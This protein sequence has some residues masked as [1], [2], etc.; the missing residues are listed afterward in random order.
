MFLTPDQAPR[1]PQTRTTLLQTRSALALLLSAAF[2]AG[3]IR[4]TTPDAVAPATEESPEE[5]QLPI[6][7]NGPWTD[8]SLSP[9]KR[10]ELL[11]AEMSQAEKLRLV[12][13]YFGS[14]AEW[15]AYKAPAEARP[16]SAGYVPGNPRLGIPPQWQTDAGIGVAT[17]GSAPKKR[18]RTALPSGLAT[19]ATWNPELAEKG[20]AMIGAEARASGFNVMLAGG[21]NLVRDAY[22]GRNFEYGGEDPYLSGVMVGAQI[23]GIQSNHIISTMKH[24]AIN[25]Q[26]TDRDKGNSIL[27]ESAARMS[28]YLA[29]Q[30]ALERGDPGSVMCAYNRVG[31]DFACE[32]KHLLSKILREDW[33]FQGYVMSDWG[34][35]HS[36][37]KAALA[38][39]EQESGWPFDEKPFFGEPLKK[40]LDTGTVPQGRL[41]EMV[42]RILTTMF[43]HGLFEHPVTETAQLIDRAKNA[44][45]SRLDAEEGAV[46]LK[47]SGALPLS[48]A[49]KKIAVI[50]GYADRGVLSG[51]GSSQVYPVGGNAVDGLSP[52]TWPGPVVYY[53]S[54]PLA[55]LKEAL[56]QAAVTFHSG[57]D[58]KAAAKLA[59]ESDVAIVFATQWATES[60]DTTIVLPDAQDD[61]INAVASENKKTVV[62]LE[63]GGAVLM[64][65]ADKVNA[66]LEAWYPGSAGGEAI[67]NLLTGK[68]N[69]SGHLPITFAKTK[70][71]LAHPDEPKAGDVTYTE[72]ATVGYK[73]FDQKKTEPLFA[74]G[75]GLSYTTFA[76]KGLGAEVSE[77]GIVAT[78]TVENTGK[79][80][81]KDVAQVY[82]GCP[83]WEAPRRLGGFS[84][85]DLAAGQSTEA[86]VSVD[87]R[88]LSTWDEKKNEFHIAPALCDVSV[89]SSSRKLEQTVKVTL[90]EGRIP[91]GKRP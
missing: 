3:C 85:V 72:G 61:L 13:G 60:I 70:D 31:G 36:T 39:L 38:G 16:G 80:A 30:F 28:D 68:V 40:A 86:T 63:T 25:D 22:N 67:A 89:G 81:G 56:P 65:W 53:P 90:A 82:V 58:V 34:A 50:G 66:I 46:L 71:Q 91:A 10:T 54:S 78:F 18:E 43:K 47:N 19:T 27:D 62:V 15:K 75:H 32:N 4:K 83:G 24:F 2:A 9:Q 35:V 76:Y 57:K 59:K 42:S 37:E 8:A 11:L 14:D 41:D 21:V 29:F 88:L 87:P 79:V 69:P 77:T 73:W 49:V 48:S 45:V 12:F 17:Q 52:T 5:E 44:T 33:A 20:G 74:F 7:E 51:G 1:S 84:K 55:A 26:E 6:I 64:P 23:A